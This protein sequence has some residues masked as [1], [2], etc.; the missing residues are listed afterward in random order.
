MGG[1]AGAGP[2]EEVTRAL[3][4]ASAGRIAWDDLRIEAE[5]ATDAGYRSAAVYGR[6]LGIWNRE[7]QFTFTRQEILAMLKALRRA[8]FGRLPETFGREAPRPR[9]PPPLVLKVVCSVSF[10]AGGVA[11]RVTQLAPGKESPVLKRLAREVLAICEK[12]ARSGLG[13]ESLADGLRK[14]ADGRLGPETL[15]LMM[16]RKGETASE[17]KGWLLRLEGVRALTRTYTPPEGYSDPVALELRPE[18]LAEVVLL[19]LDSR[20]ESLP[21][22]LYAEQYTDLA[23]EVLNR[24]K[25]IQARPFAGMEPTTHGELQRAFDRLCE[26]LLQLHLRILGEGEPEAAPGE[27]RPPLIR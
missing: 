7:R 10:A 2:A 19:L 27:E 1:S 12:P 13:A 23:V 4:D 14:L 8:G 16:H 21:A 20:L 18:Q 24:E 5:C 6:G 22:N 25:R 9:E 11:K 3:E 26:A 15:S 17:P